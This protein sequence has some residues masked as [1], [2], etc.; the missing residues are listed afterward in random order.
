M[1][2]GRGPSLLCRG[3]G[4]WLM[5]DGVAYCIRFSGDV[6]NRYVLFFSL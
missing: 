4:V 6:D 2:E 1:G 3:E 5:I